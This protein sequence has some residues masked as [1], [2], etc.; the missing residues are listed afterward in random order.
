M[1]P[2]HVKSNTY[3]DSGKEANDKNPKFKIGDVIISKYLKCFCKNLQSKL[4]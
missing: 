4:V 3:I 1:K 2:A